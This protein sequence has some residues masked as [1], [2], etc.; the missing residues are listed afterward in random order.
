MASQKGPRKVRDR[1]R[2]ANNTKWDEPGRTSRALN[3]PP[4]LERDIVVPPRATLSL[5]DAAAP[6]DGFI[7]DTE[8]MRRSQG[9]VSLQ[10]LYAF[11][12][13]SLITDVEGIIKIGKEAS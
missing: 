10:Q 8:G 9:R 7:S 13:R 2:A 12:D 5:D 6:S 11:Y 1:Q 4:P 3:G